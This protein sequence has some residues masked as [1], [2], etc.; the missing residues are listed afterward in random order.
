MGESDPRRQWTVCGIVRET[1][2]TTTSHR[3]ACW[4][5]G[6]WIRAIANPSHSAL[7]GHSH[8]EF[9]H[10]PWQ[11]ERKIQ[12]RCIHS[13]P[14][15]CPG[16]EVSTWFISLLINL[17]VLLTGGPLDQGD[18]EDLGN[19]K[20]ALI[21]PWHYFDFSLETGLSSTG[22]QVGCSN[23]TVS[24]QTERFLTVCQILSQNQVYDVRVVDGKL[25]IN[26]QSSLSLY[27]VPVT[28]KANQGKPSKK[29]LGG[30]GGEGYLLVS[31]LSTFTLS[32]QLDILAH[33]SMHYLI[34]FFSTIN[35]WP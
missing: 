21:C 7:P 23:E 26:T 15:S 16:F 13:Y 4:K 34:L 30:G 17:F 19:G 32:M 10:H 27:P 8:L 6:G 1:H 33:F 9:P 22:L 35:Y 28:K 11:L 29:K 25:Y 5:D 14:R 12:Q 2:S 18:I 31:I 3:C 20:M 24:V